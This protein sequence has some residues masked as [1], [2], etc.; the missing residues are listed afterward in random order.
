VRCYSD[1]E[2]VISSLTSWLDVPRSIQMRM[3]V[4]ASRII[5]NNDD[6]INN[7]N[8][9]NNDNNSILFYSISSTLFMC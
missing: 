5:G 2:E 8:I 1:I 7:I 4:I 9:N 6:D 3:L